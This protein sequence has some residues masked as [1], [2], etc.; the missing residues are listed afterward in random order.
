MIM[1]ENIITRK[2]LTS[3]QKHNIVLRMWLETLFFLQFWWDCQPHTRERRRLDAGM[4]MAM[5]RA[6]PTIPC[7]VLDEDGVGVATRP[8]SLGVPSGSSTL[9]L[10]PSLFF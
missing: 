2:I 1:K 8:S 4:A 6:Q 9:P 10:P 5:V 7:C 3:V